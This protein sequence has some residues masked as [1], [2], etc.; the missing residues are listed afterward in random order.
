MNPN[1]FKL[2]I[3]KASLLIKESN[4]DVDFFNIGGGFPAEYPVL[5]N[6]L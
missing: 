6:N 5:N 4:L 1:A 3:N 2:A